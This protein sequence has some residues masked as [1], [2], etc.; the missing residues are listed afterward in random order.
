M[1]LFRKKYGLYIYIISITTVVISLI[2]QQQNIGL[3][4]HQ[5]FI[6]AND[7]KIQQL[8]NLFLSIAHDRVNKKLRDKMYN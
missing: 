2:K 5:Q 8:I 3:I 1:S 7:T 6:I 4:H